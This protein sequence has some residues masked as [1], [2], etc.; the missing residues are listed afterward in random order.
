M[1]PVHHIKPET[2]NKFPAERKAAAFGSPSSHPAYHPVFDLKICASNPKVGYFL[3]MIGFI[4]TNQTGS[5]G[6]SGSWCT[7]YP[8]KYLHTLLGI[9]ESALYMKA[10]H[11]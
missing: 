11:K 8:S 10:K 6:T 9:S 2:S 4:K 5:E 1:G 3:E 7:E